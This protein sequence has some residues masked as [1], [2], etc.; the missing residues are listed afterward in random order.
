MGPL[1][2]IRKKA[3]IFMKRKGGKKKINWTSTCKMNL[4]PSQNLD[5]GNSSS[6][7]PNAMKKAVRNP[8]AIKKL[9]NG[10]D[11]PHPNLSNANG[12]KKDVSIPSNLGESFRCIK[13]EKTAKGEEYHKKHHDCCPFSNAYKKRQH[14]ISEDEKKKRKSSFFLPKRIPKTART[15]TSLACERLPPSQS[16]QPP[17]LAK[18]IPKILPVQ[19]LC[20][21]ADVLK[22]VV[23]KKKQE[24]KG[25]MGRKVPIKI[26]AVIE[27]ILSLVPK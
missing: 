23:K 22:E 9:N 24:C 3:T 2:Q 26:E 16:K 5:S 1:S 21:T 12:C 17:I 8:Y 15:K 10:N 25:Q 11:P 19:R 18:S 27:F 20:I 7:P 14:D 6:D 4:K 13:C